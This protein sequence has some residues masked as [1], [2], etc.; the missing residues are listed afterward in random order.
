MEEQL[1]TG[2]LVFLV[3]VSTLT[4][5]VVALPFVFSF[6]RHILEKKSKFQKLSDSSKIRL[7]RQLKDTSEEL[8]SKQI[9]AIITVENRDNLDKLRTD[10]VVLDSQ[11]TSALLIAIFQKNS[12]IHDGA[13]IIR[14]NRIQY[15]GTYYKITK[16]SISN[17][18]GSR[19]RAALGISE[20][21]DAVTIVISEEK[22]TILLCKQQKIEYVTPKNFQEKLVEYLD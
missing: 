16:R 17:H 4:F 9:G 22:G 5:F 6:I 1:Q 13:V 8:S 18:F 14:N 10:G 15:A 2:L 20:N 21:S 19:H 11:V 3:T 7:V 12:P